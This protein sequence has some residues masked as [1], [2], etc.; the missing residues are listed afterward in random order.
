MRIT[1]IL[2]TVLAL[3]SAAGAEMMLD[4]RRNPDPEPGLESYTLWFTGDA[5]GEALSAFDG[6]FDGALSQTWA[7]FR[8]RWSPER[9]L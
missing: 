7:S 4:V 1:A 5:A 8:G 9:W 3:A 2:A 6:R